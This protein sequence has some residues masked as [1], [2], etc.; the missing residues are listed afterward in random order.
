M[1][2]KQGLL[3]P[4]ALV[5]LGALGFF[6]PILRD[7]NASHLLNAAWVG[8][9]RFHLMWNLALWL[10]LGIYSLYLIWWR[11]GP[12]GVS[13]LYSALWLQGF[14]LLAFWI[15]LALGPLYGGRVV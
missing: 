13:N 9:A 2:T 1:A 10:G 12:V 15:A 14:N 7:T 6:G 4:R 5:T 8:H 3:A 11:S